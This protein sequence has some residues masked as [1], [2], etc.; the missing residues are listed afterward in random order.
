[1]VEVT[2]TRRLANGVVLNA[3]SGDGRFTWF[4]CEPDVVVVRGSNTKVYCQG[5]PPRRPGRPDHPAKPLPEEVESQ[6][7][8]FHE[9][10]MQI[11]HASWRRQA[12]AAQKEARATAAPL[13]RWAM[14]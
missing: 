9:I 13:E 8:D 3:E 1:M 7:R 11:V 10:L 5:L 6:A 14:T 2:I 12:Q 4:A